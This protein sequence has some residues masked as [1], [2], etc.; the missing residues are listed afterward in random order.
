MTYSLIF[1]H[2]VARHL[3]FRAEMSLGHLVS[4][5]TPQPDKRF[6]FGV[7]QGRKY[8]AVA[9]ELSA[10]QQ[11]YFRWTYWPNVETQIIKTF[12][13][14]ITSILSIMRDKLEP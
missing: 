6:Y 4:S 11:G 8:R 3:L 14:N 2:S 1:D 5:Q 12:G 9:Y 7:L 13:G 10:S